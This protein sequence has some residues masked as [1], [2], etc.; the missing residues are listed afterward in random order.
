MVGGHNLEYVEETLVRLDGQA[1]P[2]KQ[3]P[4]DLFG[5][6]TGWS[7]MDISGRHRRRRFGRGGSSAAFR[8]PTGWRRR[9]AGMFLD[10]TP[11]WPCSAAGRDLQAPD[12]A[13]LHPED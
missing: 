11:R 1:V 6:R 13:Y 4:A 3:P 7:R 12:L 9:Q 8:T 2:L 10:V 5:G